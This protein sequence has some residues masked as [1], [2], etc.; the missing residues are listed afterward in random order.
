MNAPIPEQGRRQMLRQI[1][2][3]ALVLVIAS[4][5]LAPYLRQLL[6]TPFG[7]GVGAALAAYIMRR[8]WTDAA[9][10]GLPVVAAE[11]LEMGLGP[12][13]AVFFVLPLFAVTARARFAAT[14]GTLLLGLLIT[15][16]RMKERFA[17]TLLTLRDMEF[18]FL[19]FRDNV[20][21]MASQ[22]TL[23]A[24][25]GLAGVGIGAVA[26]ASWRLDARAGTHVSVPLRIAGTSMTLLLAAWNSHEL[27]GEALAL[28]GRP[29]WSLAE[30]DLGD[31]H[32]LARF[33]SS[34]LLKATWVPPSHETAGF[35]QHVAG[36][37]AAPRVAGSPADIVVFLQESQ[38]NPA[39]IDG[40]PAR[41]C[42]LDVFHPTAQN[43]S[44]GPLQVHVFGGGTWLSE[45][46]IATGVPHQAFGAAGDF[47]PFNVAPGTRRS[48]I[49]SL[50]AAGYRTA[51]VY[52]TRGGMMNGRLAYAGYGFD[53]FYDAAD[54]GLPG[55]FDT[56]DEAMHAAARKVLAEERSHGQ[57][58]FLLVLTIFNHGEHGVHMDR[59]PRALQADAALY[60]KREEEAR[61]V[62]DYVWRT[63]EFGK[64]LGKTRSAVLEAGR[65]AVFAWFG[66]HQPPFS[67]ALELRDRIHAVPT[68]EGQVPSKFQTWYQ[69]SSNVRHLPPRRDFQP[70]DI[71][72]LPGLLAQSAGVPLDDWLSANVAARE[73]CS[74]LLEGCR[75][76]GAA[77]AYLTYLWEDLKAFELP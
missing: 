43:V 49:R 23:L 37:Q 28:A 14:M 42:D 22:P 66:D 77:E 69:V 18:F 38:F 45:F 10:L 40:C 32:P 51:A 19:R 25:L 27:R 53:R 35:A 8:R 17:G 52:P 67:S 39:T 70:L 48:F 75:H 44:N 30:R 20:G 56:S 33:V 24:Y 65:P 21:V 57:P 68:R 31:P 2:W 46:A 7:L 29:P 6:V 13:L 5:L 47:A 62:A 58:V 26:W 61:N 73:E 41:L 63:R 74:G 16:I 50:K 55:S 11:A 71:V 9:F 60:F 34:A 59:V 3:C 12:Q 1:V 4:F 36:L 72:F 76:E 54:L 64:V 15:S